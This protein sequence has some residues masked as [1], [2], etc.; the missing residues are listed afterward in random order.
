[1][2]STS[3]FLIKTMD[4]TNIHWLG[5]FDQS[6]YLRQSLD[7]NKKHQILCLNKLD[8]KELYNIWLLSNF[9]KPTSQA[10]FESVFMGNVFEWGKIYILP[11]IVT[12]DSRI[13]VFQYKVLHNVLYLN[14]KLLKFNKIIYLKHSFIQNLK[15]RQLFIC[16][17]FEERRKLYGCN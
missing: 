17:I 8:R 7:Q 11:R 10:Y 13:W 6:Y 2:N 3:P 5:K 4:K 16:F 14:K 15:N 1:M 9:L 12:T